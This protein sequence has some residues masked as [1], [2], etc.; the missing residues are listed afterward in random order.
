M[1]PTSGYS[2]NT[3]PSGDGQAHGVY[4]R[5]HPEARGSRLSGSDD[6]IR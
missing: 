4:G 3:L 2:V 1:T 6:I 5:I